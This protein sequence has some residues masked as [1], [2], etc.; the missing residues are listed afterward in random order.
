MLLFFGA[1]LLLAVAGYVYY[2]V[3]TARIRGEKYRELLSIGES[4]A[5]E[6]AH[7]RK[8]CL[9]DAARL[10]RNGLLA[11]A[12][13]EVQSAPPAPAGMEHLQHLLSLEIEEKGCRAAYIRD[14]E[15]KLLAAEPEAP[16]SVPA[17]M[18][19]AA[20]AAVARGEEVLSR[21][22]PDQSGEV[23][24]DAVAPVF[25]TTGKI[26]AVLTLRFAAEDYLY[27]LLQA[28]PFPSATAENTLA[29]KMAGEI[30]FVSRLRHVDGPPFSRRYPV[31]ELQIPAVQAA[32]GRR[33][34]FEGADYRGERVL[35]DL[36]A[37]PDSE[38]VLISKIDE[39]ECLAAVRQQ[40]R[41][42]ALIIA[43][44]TVLAAFMIAFRYRERQA[45][46]YRVM[47]QAEQEL[48]QANEEFRLALYSIGDAVITADGLGRVKKM[49][50]QAEALTGWIESEAS[51]KPLEDVFCIVNGESGE[52][53]PSPVHQVMSTGKAA[54]LATHTLLRAR[55][56]VKRPIADSSAPI[57]DKQGHTSGV[58]LVFRDQSAERAAEAAMKLQMTRLEAAEA[59]A[60]L[61][62]WEFDVPSGQGWCSAQMCAM[63]GLDAGKP[64]PKLEEFLARVHPEDR[65]AIIGAMDAIL[66]GEGPPGLVYR[67]NPEWGD[68]RYFAP[69]VYRGSN[70]AGEPIRYSGT[71]LDITERSIFENQLRDREARYRSLFEANP[72]PMWVFDLESLAFVEV[73]D[74]ATVQYGYS[75]KEFLAMSIA[76]IRPAEDRQLLF[77]TLTRVQDEGLFKSDN[78]RHCRKDG[79]RIDV[80]MVSHK[81]DFAGRACRLVLAHDI[82][83]QKRAADALA[84]REEQFRLFIEYSPAAIAMFD[85]D[86]RYLAASRRWH[87]DYDLLDRDLIGRSHYDVFPDLP[88]RW[89]AIHRRCLEGATEKCDEDPFPRAG[90][91]LDWMRWEVHPWHREDGGIGGILVFSEVVTDRKIASLSLHAITNRLQGILD[92]SPLLITEIDLEGQYLL[93]NK[94]ACEILGVEQSRLVGH[95]YGEFLDPGTTAHFQN[96]IQ[97]VCATGM[98]QPVEDSF[99]VGGVTRIFSSVLF[100]LRNENREITSIGGIAADI[101]EAR[102]AEARREVLEEQLRQSQKLESIG[103]LA[104]GVAHDFN[105]ML[106]VI[107]GHAGFAIQTPDLSDAV[108]SDLQ[109]IINAAERSAE[110]TRQLLAFA[111]KQT[112]APKVLDLNDIVS[113]QIKMLGRLIGENIDLIWKPGKALWPVKMDPAQVHQL[114]ANLMVN[115]RDAIAGNGA[116][117]LET[118][119]RLCGGPGSNCREEIEPGDYVILTVRDSGCGMD[120]DTLA[121]IFEPFFTTK[122]IGEGTGLGLSTVYG[123]ARQNRGFVSVHSAP[124]EG[125]TFEIGFPRETQEVW[126]RDGAGQKVCVTGGTETILLVEDETALLMLVRRLLEHLGYSVLAAPSPLDALELAE[127]HSGG[128]DVLV[129]DVIMPGMSGRMLWDT[130]ASRHPALKCL[131]LSGYT[132]DFIAHEGILDSGVHFLAKPFTEA[133]LAAK[134]RETL[135]GGRT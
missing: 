109:A 111:R 39:S 32:L 116:V 78:V 71:V 91:H 58:V 69:S 97:L 11:S 118:A 63:H 25:D 24:I 127:Q 48:G 104:G 133:A 108:R 129:T 68:V 117:S 84:I 110:L 81:L 64:F 15:G 60:R 86:M 16:A 43:L 125:A 18:L 67:T 55:D 87:I 128:I 4:K 14:L 26:L 49:N 57:L 80:Q 34:I 10:S 121:H 46:L 51:G 72:H 61:G 95:R 89:K 124:G 9:S 28:W 96:R 106:G 52:S 74:A 76:D 107:L 115:A 31:T 53:I 23:W 123:I 93:V 79:S 65:A 62:S 21:L 1:A 119:N 38:W 131:F 40:S 17:E 70:A 2:R 13:F 82:T 113:G 132:A 56:G 99:T 85:R 33:G 73:N 88:E 8:E 103:R 45:D 105:N 47:F 134:L 120:Q 94:A 90:G 12:V 59:H 30:V 75:R 5:R 92:H 98:P 77:Q 22:Y 36:C 44:A 100:P 50:P 19:A 35:A 112:I 54:G 3:D 42:T 27:P 41:L 101:T 7:W 29:V 122:A 20:D 37:I 6:I 102:Q 66:R 126:T 130:L 114:L 83:E 135:A